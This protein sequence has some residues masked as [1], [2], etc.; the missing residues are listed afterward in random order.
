[1]FIFQSLLLFVIW[2]SPSELILIRFLFLSNVC[3]QFLLKQILLKELQNAS[4]PLHNQT[5]FYFLNSSK[6]IFPVVFPIFLNN[7]FYLCLSIAVLSL[8][9]LPFPFL[10]AFHI[11]FTLFYCPS[12]FRHHRSL[13]TNRTFCTVR[14]LLLL[15]PSCTT[16][17]YFFQNLQLPKVFF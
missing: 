5:L 8:P 9:L 4:S 1:M 14:T 12:T 16:L 11:G 2:F 17:H 13:R 7:I 6:G 10:H 3:T 15:L